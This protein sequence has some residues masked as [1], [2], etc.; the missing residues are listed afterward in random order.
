[1]CLIPKLNIYDFIWGQFIH[2]DQ[3]TSIIPSGKTVIVER[4]VSGTAF[5]D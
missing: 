4:V 5:L 3:T 2:Q 1:M